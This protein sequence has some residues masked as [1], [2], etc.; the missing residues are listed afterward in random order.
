[1]S[2]IHDISIPQGGHS[3]GS[4][5]LGVVGSWHRPQGRQTFGK[6]YIQSLIDS[7]QDSFGYLIRD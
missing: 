6:I 5:S 1:M 4:A 7:F 2:D 3:V